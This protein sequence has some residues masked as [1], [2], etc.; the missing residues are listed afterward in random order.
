M[1]TFIF[2][3]VPCL[4]IYFQ[5]RENTMYIAYGLIGVETENGAAK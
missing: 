2:C 1:E 3:A 5:Q 4:H